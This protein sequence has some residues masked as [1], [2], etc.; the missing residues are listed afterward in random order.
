MPTENMGIACLH[1]EWT[2][3]WDEGHFWSLCIRVY[4]K[5]AAPLGRSSPTERLRQVSPW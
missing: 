3:R 2:R 5:L 4:S 1:C